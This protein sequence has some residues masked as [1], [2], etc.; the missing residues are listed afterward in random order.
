M[1][2]FLCNFLPC[3][4][5]ILTFIA[6]TS[7]TT[8]DFLFF[9]VF[10][11]RTTPQKIS[12]RYCAA[13]CN[14]FISNDPHMLSSALNTTVLYFIAF[15]IPEIVIFRFSRIMQRYSQT[16]ASNSKLNRVGDITPYWVTPCMFW[17]D[18]WTNIINF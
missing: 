6:C 11:F 8:P 13:S 9:V 4:L 14:H 16:T 1:A 12:Q 15:P 18:V 7:A 5:S 10:G 3:S 2:L 17:L